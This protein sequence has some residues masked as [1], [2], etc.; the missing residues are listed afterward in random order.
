MQVYS[1]V[2]FNYLE[3]ALQRRFG[4]FQRPWLVW[5]FTRTGYVLV[6]GMV[7]MLVPFFG[8]MMSFLGAFGFIPTS[9]GE[10]IPSSA[11]Q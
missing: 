3:L 10:Q 8:L 6:C 7:G 4:P 5:L 1:R 2:V 9:F 11:Q